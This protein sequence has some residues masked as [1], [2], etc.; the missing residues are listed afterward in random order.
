MTDPTMDEGLIEV[1]LERLEKQRLPRLLA[2]KEKVDGGNKLEDFDLDFLEQSMA[3]AKNIIPIIDRRPAYQ[4]LAAK[5]MDLYKAITEKAL[6]IEKK[7]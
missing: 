3:D 4:P 7:S 2:I 5:V 1:I 6:E